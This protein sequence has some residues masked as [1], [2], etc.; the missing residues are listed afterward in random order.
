MVCNFKLL[1][2]SWPKQ[3]TS[4][5]SPQCVCLARQT[6]PD[7]EPRWL[8]TTVIGWILDLY[9]KRWLGGETPNKTECQESRQKQK[10]WVGWI[11]L[12][13][14]W[15]QKPPLAG[16]FCV[17]GIG[18]PSRP[19][20]L[21]VCLRAQPSDPASGDGRHGLR[22]RGRRQGSS[23]AKMLST[24]PLKARTRVRE[25][26]V[27]RWCTREHPDNLRWKSCQIMKKVS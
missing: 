5:S 27:V 4:Q 8:G 14:E 23:Q 6:T 17:D 22:R 10:Q 25:T 16:I 12:L 24:P 19:I 9:F 26:P 3:L 21:C 7:W 20:W 11:V 13:K 1:R 2:S 15:K 18:R